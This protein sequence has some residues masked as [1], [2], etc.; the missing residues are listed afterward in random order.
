LKW[1]VDRVHG[2]AVA[3][4]E[5]LGW[6]PRYEDID[7]RGLKF[8]KEEFEEVM[9]TD[10]DDWVGELASHDQMFFKLYRRLPR[11]FHSIRDLKLASLWRGMGKS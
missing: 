6:R 8:S 9:E 11:E 10:E 4:E 3:V 1:I 2:R 7:W 5:V